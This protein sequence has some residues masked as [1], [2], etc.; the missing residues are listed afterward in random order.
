[1]QQTDIAQQQTVN[2]LESYRRITKKLIRKRFMRKPNIGEVIAQ[3]E[4]LIKAMKR[5]GEHQFA[6]FC[7]LAVARCH[8]ALQNSTLEALSL[9]DA[10]HIFWESEKDIVTTNYFGFH[11]YAEEAQHCYLLAIKI[12]LD[13]KK[14]LM[15]ASLYYEMANCLALLKRTKEAAIYFEKA[16]ELQ[17]TECAMAA[18]DSLK[19]A[20]ECHFKHKN[21]TKALETTQWIIKLSTEQSH[22]NNNDPFYRNIKDEAMISLVL[23]LILSKD[24]TQASE[25]VKQ[26]R[27]EQNVSLKKVPELLS[28]VKI[29]F[30]PEWVFSLLDTLIE[31]V[32]NKEEK[33]VLLVHSELSKTLNPFQ[34]EVFVGILES[35]KPTPFLL[36]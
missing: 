31:A 32:E 30:T 12:Y 3:Y 36:V 11:E 16:A 8:H 13:Q 2:Y 14:C 29:Y 23:L 34:N 18:L 5:D 28:D 10:G 27:R 24:F 33:T 21:L 4:D 15:A 25:M 35:S 22:L 26:M 17:Q 7:C 20:V 19:N 6:A 9:V 1:M